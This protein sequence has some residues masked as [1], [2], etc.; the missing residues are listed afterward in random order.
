MTICIQP[1]S[2]ESVVT[3]AE[4]ETWSPGFSLVK[5]LFT[6]YPRQQKKLSLT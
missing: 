1:K 3:Y 4:V 6:K 2:V 5:R